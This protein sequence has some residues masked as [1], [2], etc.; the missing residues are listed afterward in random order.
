MSVA[1]A[2][3]KISTVTSAIFDG[4]HQAVTLT[5]GLV[6]ILAFWM[7]ILRIAQEAGLITIFSRFLRPL[8]RF[9][10]PS[11]PPDHPAAGAIVMNLSANFLGMG[12]AATP[13]GLEAMRQLQ[14]LNPDPTTA[15]PAMCTL[16]ALNTSGLMLLPTTAIGLRAQMG[17]LHPSA[18]VLPTLVATAIGTGVAILADRIFRHRSSSKP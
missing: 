11:V 14:K 13:I 2:T 5:I 15:S 3:G 17:S 18:I 8:I 10:F 16:L 6:G 12:N 1:G 4:A 9:L 7:G